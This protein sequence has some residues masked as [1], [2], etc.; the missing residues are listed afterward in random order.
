MP[1]STNRNERGQSLVELAVSLP[2]M[3][4]LLLGTMEFGM[5]IFSYAIIRDAAQ[6]GALYGSFNP[7][8]REEIE[9]RARNISPRGEDA[10]FSSPVELRNTDT[11]RVN[12]EALGRACQGITGGTA[13]SLRV[14]V[15]YQYPILMP[16]AGDIIGSDTVSLTGSATNVIL[17]PPCP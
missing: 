9:N 1:I 10:V 13:N 17:Q 6:E 16:F 5:A 12:I 14:S 8:N 11:V 4:L 15:S 7:T 2:V 3:I